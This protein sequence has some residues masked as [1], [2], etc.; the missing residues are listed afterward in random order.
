MNPMKPTLLLRILLAGVLAWSATLLRAEEEQDLI[1][2]LQS[3]ASAPQKWA[4]CQRLRI[5]GTAKAVPALATLLTEE[6]LSQA[7]RHALEALPS[8]AAD[9]ALGDALE[10]TTGLLKA[11]VID[12]LGRRGELSSVP[13]LTPLL[14]DADPSIAAAAAASLG[15]IGGHDAIAALLAARDQAPLA[16]QSAVRESL[17]QCADGLAAKN[18]DSGALAVYRR[19][20]EEKSPVPIR[21]AAWRG[22]VLANSAHRSEM[23]LQALTGSDHAIRVVA[24]KLVQELRDPVLIHACLSQW[25]ALPPDS[26]LALLEA[27]IKLG[28]E[29][30]S[31]ARAAAQS[32]D[33]ALRVAAWQAL[34]ELNDLDS[35]PAL[36]KAACGTESTEREAAHT[37]L[38]RLRGP[39]AV[40]ALLAEVDHAAAPQKAELL[41]VLGERQDHTA[42]K[43]LLQNAASEDQ[44]VRLAALESLK[45][46]AP[47]EALK[48]LLEM[49]VSTKS[50]DR[51]EPILQA[52][53]A[54]CDASPDRDE[55]T[56]TVVAA[57]NRAPVAE[58][59][60]ILPL[61]ANLGTSGALA[62]ALDASRNPDAELAKEAARVLAQ[63]PNAAPAGSLLELARSSTDPTLQAL[64]LR[65]AIQVAGQEPDTAKRLGLLE[66]AMASA[67]RLDEKKQALGQIGQLPTPPALEVAIKALTEP[68]LTDEASLAALAIAEKLAATNP[69]LA[70][71]AASKVLAQVKEGDVARRAWA[72]RRKPGID[73]PFI[74]NWVVCG[75]YRRAGAVGARAV[76]D[77]PFEPEK[78]ES[79]IEW[80]TV[81]PADHV[82]LAVLFPG[83][84]NCAAYL[85]TRIIAPEDCNGLLLMGSDD[86][87]KVWLNGKV[88]HSNNVDRGEIT[89]QDTAPISLK[90]GANELLLKI[91]QGGGGWSACARIVGSDFKPIS[92]LQVECPAG[93]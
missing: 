85:R 76:F 93:I 83:Q 48:P 39:G 24:L 61:L 7:A 10:K 38:A 23:V 8:P 72:L 16:V 36:A 57:V 33:L 87:V 53:Y 32:P 56:R 46:L 78:I 3:T 47:P 69:D 63:W 18:D 80:K 91:T 68:G 30:K 11:G 86:G 43:V 2:T 12:S 6:G 92:G 49:E 89:D 4:A 25:A 31:T 14:L 15:R 55:A 88:A 58:R 17:L 26:R 34:G 60:T 22:L 21:T 70:D 50:D 81:P 28:T 74:R 41:R 40:D 35:I 19:L 64:A 66:Q 1:A 13:R 82:N 44:T 29:A 59:R 67:S 5:I 51:R 54:V 84:E 42:A 65:G 77:I 62:A 79:K 20:F 90:K 71:L 9:A 37:S 45:E 27:Q 73:A 52:L 75:P